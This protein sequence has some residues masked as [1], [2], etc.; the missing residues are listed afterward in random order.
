L[1]ASSFT[2][3]IRDQ[4]ILR[5]LPGRYRGILCAALLAERA[6]ANYV[7]KQSENGV[8]ISTRRPIFSQRTRKSPESKPAVV[9]TISKSALLSKRNSCASRF[10][11]SVPL[12]QSSTAFSS[13]AVHKRRA[14]IS[15]SVK[16][17]CVWLAHLRCNGLPVSPSQYPA[18]FAPGLTQL[19]EA[20]GA[21][22]SKA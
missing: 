15:S 2:A 5:Y 7:A 14:E 19:A 12:R 8:R 3:Q 1:P 22:M 6:R 9:Q 16:V 21:P 17:R 18:S 20:S 10:A 4:Q 11:R 13:T